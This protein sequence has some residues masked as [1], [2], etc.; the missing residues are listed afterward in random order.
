MQNSQDLRIVKTK[1][2]L[3]G[4]F[5]RMMQDRSFDEI[6]VF[7]LCDA[8]QVRRA[9]FY[10]HYTDK[11]HFLSSLVTEV[12]NEIVGKVGEIDE[13]RDPIEYYCSYVKEVLSYFRSHEDVFR[14]I[15]SSSAFTKVKDIILHGT[16][17]A[18]KHDLSKAIKS[19]IELPA[20]IDILSEFLNGGIAHIVILWLTTEGV[21]DAMVLDAVKSL[22][23]RLLPTNN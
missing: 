8:A 20:R 4:A 15:I 13:N 23:S 2:K 17:S 3:R 22:M 1:M 10:R 21:T 6:T 11:Y 19:G 14:N 18:F 12:L 7:D 9:T 16:L 5:A